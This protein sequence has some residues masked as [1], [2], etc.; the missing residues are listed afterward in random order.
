MTTEKPSALL[1]T[2]HQP[3]GTRPREA[4]VPAIRALLPSLQPSE[5]R[6]AAVVLADP[7]RVVSMSVTELAAEAQSSASTVVRC[8]QSL[9]F[10]GFHDLKLALARDSGMSGPVTPSQ[11]GAD[12]APKTILE[13]LLLLD[14][15]ALR[16]AHTTVDADQLA[17]A[18]DA[19]DSAGMILLAGV[20][21]SS[22]MAQDISFR[23]RT[24]GLRSEAPDDIH[25]QL[26]AARFLRPGDV[27]LVIS[28]SGATKASY[29]TAVAAKEAGATVIAVTSF[30]RSPLTELAD[31]SI[32]AGGRETSSFRFEAMASRVVHMCLLDALFVALAMR[33]QSDAAEHWRLAAEL[34]AD[35]R[36]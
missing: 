24:I 25:V 3:A 28:H 6:V 29:A 19:C 34:L 30:M 5:A 17:A 14:A 16:Q 23:F 12:D 26:V 20:G 18:V 33:R 22:N 13:K 7:E 10:R 36:F 4:A 15:D 32:V 2:T 31:I 11:L 21:T 1:D 8:C 9:G 35:Q 27:C